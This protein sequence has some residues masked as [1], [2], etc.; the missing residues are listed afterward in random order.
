MHINT[1]GTK[2]NLGDNNAAVLEEAKASF[3][4]AEKPYVNQGNAPQQ[5]SLRNLGRVISGK[6][7]EAGMVDEIVDTLKSIAD[8]PA[9]RK[10][11]QASVVN[12]ANPRLKAPIILIAA[13]N[14]ENGVTAVRYQPVVIG[15]LADPSWVR[16]KEEVI[17]RHSNTTVIIDI[18]QVAVWS[19]L[20]QKWGEEALIAHYA[21]E[22]INLAPGA[23]EFA[24]Y[25]PVVIPDYVDLQNEEVLSNLMLSSLVR[26]S[27]EFSRDTQTIDHELLSL[28]NI[29][30]HQQPVE[31][32]RTTYT[33]PMASPV[34]ADFISRL[35]L[36]EEDTQ[37][38]YRQ[39]VMEVN[40][41]ENISS[42]QAVE[43]A[44]T[45]DF[46]ISDIQK[47]SVDE[48]RRMYPNEVSFPGYVPLLVVTSAHNVCAGQSQM[49]E[50]TRTQL[51]GLLAT[52]PLMPNYSWARVF[53]DR[54]KDAKKAS[55]GNLSFEW[56]PTLHGE[57]GSEAPLA[58]NSA[59]GSKDGKISPLDYAKLFCTED[60][61][62]AID[63][64]K[65]SFSA[66]NQALFF[67]A[68]TS[69]NPEV[70]IA[71][72]Y[73][74][75]DI[76]TNQMFSSVVREMF[77]GA[78]P[79]I[80]KRETVTHQ[81]GT[82]TLKGD[83]RSVGDLD[84]LAVC[85]ATGNDQIARQLAT[86]AM[87]MVS[88]EISQVR[89]TDRRAMMCKILN[90][91]QIDSLA[92]RIFIEPWFANALAMALSRSGIRMTTADVNPYQTVRT[93]NNFVASSDFARSLNAGNLYDGNQRGAVD[94]TQPFAGI[95]GARSWNNR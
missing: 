13:L 25:A 45:L 70:A 90:G 84:Y 64:V 36:V 8:A 54:P 80:V 58:S 33:G 31:I 71:E 18:P 47:F 32:N 3:T 17:D 48:I 22:G 89:L 38:T 11:V 83:R 27:E 65:G 41:A 16:T 94:S 23:S 59:S 20:A 50:N 81:T 14:E 66:P 57:I 95:G 93:R 62:L 7:D 29:R 68:A 40:E 30:L 37:S 34:S 39:N 10:A 51:L 52:L 72:L 55:I 21:E 60:V 76:L 4:K 79:N 75:C 77:D 43:A 91:V 6:A 28:D 15:R 69:P 24:Y 61:A 44:I 49:I 5:R 86:D 88:T 73:A 67:E 12:I 82:H 35:S 63:Y 42:L 74:E 19:E 46:L 1:K 2:V 9:N 53:E 56:D 78:R 26:L 85:A 92:T 87:V